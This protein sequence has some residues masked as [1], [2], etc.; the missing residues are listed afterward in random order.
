MKKLPEVIILSILFLIT[1]Y[2]L[3]KVDSTTANMQQYVQVAHSFLDGHLDTPQ[4]FDSSYYNGKYFWPLGPLPAILMMP[5]IFTGLAKQEYLAIILHTITFLSLYFLACKNGLNKIDSLWFV[6]AFFAGSIYL[7]LGHYPSPWFLAQISAFAFSASAIYTFLCKKSYFWSGFLLSLSGLCRT[8]TY[9]LSIF[10]LLIIIRSKE[11]NK[12]KIN[13]LTRFFLPILISIL[14]LGLYNYSRFNSPFESGYKHQQVNKRVA[15]QIDKGIFSLSHI[16]SN[17]Y[18]F[19]IK[20]PEPV[21]ENNSPGSVIYPYLHVNPWGMSIFFT[22]PI[23]ILLFFL[24]LKK[25]EVQNAIFTIIITLIPILTYYGIGYY[26]FGFRYA[27]DVYPLLFLLILS[28]LVPK[29]A[30]RTKT[31]IALSCLFNFFLLSHF[32]F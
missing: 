2:F 29:I 13:Q 31:L 5:F 26:Q 11:T 14:I 23:I 8:T 25:N 30:A 7:S 4:I 20:S 1:A 10:F 17:L 22:S 19:L 3:I 15:P 9:P 16:P 32:N 21:L 24:N 6:L 28:V 18:Y 12:Q 27:L